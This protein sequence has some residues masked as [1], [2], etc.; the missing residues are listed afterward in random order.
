M[1]RD[2]PEPWILPWGV[3]QKVAQRNRARQRALASVRGGPE[4][5]RARSDIEVAGQGDSH[6][7]ALG[8][9]HSHTSSC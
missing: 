9:S 8:S 2:P 7:C 4:D 6:S 5:A 1:K 3:F